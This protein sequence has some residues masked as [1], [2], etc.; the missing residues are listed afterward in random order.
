M[1]A[2][3]R[4]R[5]KRIRGENNFSGGIN[6]GLDPFGIGEN[7]STYE[8]GWDTDNHPFLAT[9]K[10]RTAH[11]S[12]G[13]G[14]TNLLTAFGNTHLVRAVGTSLQ[15]NSSGTTWTNI[16]GTF[17]NT[18]WDA[19]NFE[20][21]GA[22]ALVLVNGTDA[23]RV[24]NG[25]S[26]STL[27]GNPPVGKYI[28][29]D[30][31]RLWIAKDD[32]I[33]FSGYLDAEDWSSA[34]NSGFIQYYTERGGNIT[35]L[36]NFYGDKYVW[37]KD[38]MAV[39]QGTNYYNFQLKE[40]SNDVGCVS[41]KTIQ[42]VGDALFWLGE[43]DVYM[44][45]GGFPTPI[46]DPIRG[47]LNRINRAQIGKCCAI[48]DGIKYYLCLVLDSATEP[49][50]RLVYDPRY[51]IWRVCASNEN[52]RY[53]VLF[54]NQA[55]VGDSSGQVYR[56]NDGS[57]T[58]S[59]E[60]ITRPFDEGIGEAEK[61]YKELHLQGYFPS[62]TTVQVYYST[63]DRGSNWTQIE[64][65]PATATV[66]QNKNMIIPLDTIPLTHWIKFRL[67]GTGP[68]TIYNMQRYFRVCRVQH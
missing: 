52:Y 36:K 28:T 2:V 60:I 68:V 35:G 53:S 56:F 23:P 57:F 29:N 40:I 12:A 13:G 27:G 63:D 48:T 7:Q 61:E 18:D 43:R 41:F 38:S 42:E 66:A 14:V 3:V 31:L 34:E 55:Y 46:G 5:N 10:G 54:N 39:I 51:R 64:F 25:S 15:Y 44:F 22:P 1:G 26:L 11:G 17:A 33:H 8:M 9:P 21:N 49:N 32:I 24:W 47:Y 59:W 37:K 4:S 62:G 58:G 20:V 67:T 50:I 19:T 30:T 6:T 16:S 65:N 45:Q